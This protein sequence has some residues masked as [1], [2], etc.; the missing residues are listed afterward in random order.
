M[1]TQ[2][3]D[4]IHLYLGCKFVMKINGTN[5]LTA[6]MTFG[7]DALMAAMSKGED[8]I[9]PLLMLRPLSSMTDKEIDELASVLLGKETHCYHKWRSKEGDCIIAEW[10]KCDVPPPYEKEYEYMT[11]G[12]LIS[13]DFSIK[14]KWDYHNKKGTGTTN[15]P[16]HNYQEIT[17]YLL[18]KYFDLFNLIESGHAIE[19]KP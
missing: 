4:V 11:M 2:L 3:K 17:C 14:H 1:Q 7:V 12:M 5:D 18:S 15:E 8:V 10:K 16:L 19:Y 13:E 6:P 9:S